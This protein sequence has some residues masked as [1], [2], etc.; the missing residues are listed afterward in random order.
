M[1]I[2]IK[3]MSKKIFDSIVEELL[4]GVDLD[5]MSEKDKDK[6]SKRIMDNLYYRIILKSIESV[7]ENKK[8]DLI[9]ELQFVRDDVD[10]VIETLQKYISNVED[11]IAQVM[12]EY[13]E[14]L[15]KSDSL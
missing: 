3:I 14:E 4:S 2:K 1:T 11:I 13:K 8:D 6:L 5:G 10:A 9:N 7:D 12:G 15:M